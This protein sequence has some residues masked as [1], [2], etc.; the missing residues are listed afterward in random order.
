MGVNKVTSKALFYKIGTEVGYNFE[1]CWDTGAE[2]SIITEDVVK[3]LGLEPLDS[4]HDVTVV[5]LHGETKVKKYEIGVTLPNH[6]NG[7]ML[8]CACIPSNRLKG[9]H[10]LIGYDLISIGLFV[11]DKSVFTFTLDSAK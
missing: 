4:N 10:I 1:I 11:L 5:T 8:K 3:L 9:F 6:S 2:E 7:I